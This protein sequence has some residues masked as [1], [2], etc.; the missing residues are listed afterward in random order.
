MT[1]WPLSLLASFYALW[2]NSTQGNTNKY[3][4]TILLSSWEH[5]SAITDSKGM[6]S[7]DV[8]PG[9]YIVRVRSGYVIPP[10]VPDSE[11][12]TLEPKSD[13]ENQMLVEWISNT[14][15]VDP[16]IYSYPIYPF[17][18]DTPVT[19][20]QRGGVKVSINCDTGIR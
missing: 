7:V 18:P 12:V 2:C 15:Q 3:D 4:R 14:I 11:P 20:P 13:T 9:D 16:T 5:A 10:P 19:V 6:F 17:R 1:R 8:A